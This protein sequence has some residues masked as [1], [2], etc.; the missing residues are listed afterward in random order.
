MSQCCRHDAFESLEI[1]C[2]TFARGT[3]TPNLAAI[4]HFFSGSFSLKLLILYF[5]PL[6]LALVQLFLFFI[7]FL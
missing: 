3:N 4:D 5:Y 2:A 6:L 1:E 7:N